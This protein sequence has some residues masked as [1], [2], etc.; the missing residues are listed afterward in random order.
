MKIISKCINKLCP[1]INEN[2]IMLKELLYANYFHDCIKN[3]DW[4]TN[5][6]F[7]PSK[8]AAN[9]S[10]LYLLFNILENYS[11]QNI[12]EFGLGQSSKITTRYAKNK[13]PSAKLTIIDNNKNWIDVFSQGLEL[14]ANTK[15]ELKETETI[16]NKSIRY[17]LA[18]PEDEKF[19]FIIVDGPLGAKQK[20]P[21]TNI[22]DLIPQNLAEKFIIIID[23]YERK[24][25]QNT[26]K[27]LFSKLDSLNIKHASSVTS[28]MK[29][30]LLITS[31][32]CKFLHWI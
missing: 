21:R 28:G 27:M 3:S 12:L 16:E 32:H 26:A 31:E 1:K 18:F 4:L 25:E 19:D 20:T 15:I 8:G 2:N 14:S 22:L 5:Q 17:K 30:Q 7:R 9:Y 29:K 11:P 24:G 10:F 13:Q 6:A 23:D